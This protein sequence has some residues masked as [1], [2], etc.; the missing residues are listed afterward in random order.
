MD[1]KNIENS[2]FMTVCS[3][4]MEGHIISISQ[5]STLDYIVNEIVERWKHLS[6]AMIEIKF[7]IPNNS[8]IFI[9]LIVDKDIRNMYEIYLKLKIVIIKM[10]VSHCVSSTESPKAVI[11]MR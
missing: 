4:G 3:Y 6:S 11:N 9:K 1:S 7:Y 2:I 8:R 10:V 5:D